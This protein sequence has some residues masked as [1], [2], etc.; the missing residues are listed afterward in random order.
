MVKSN[1]TAWHISSDKFSDKLSDIKKLQF[2]AHYAVLAPSGHNTQPWHFSHDSTELFLELNQERNLPFSGALAAEPHISLGACL[3]TLVLAA[4][5]FGYQLNITY[6]FKNK[7]IASIKLASR[8]NPDSEI[9]G[10]IVQRVSNRNNYEMN[11][12]KQGVLAQLTGEKLEFVSAQ[13]VS[14]KTEIAFLAD[15]TKQ[16][17]EH[18]MTEPK[19]R[20][21]LSKWVRNNITR[22]HDGMPGFVQGMP[23]PPSLIAKHIIRN[24]DI[25]KGQAKKDSE[26]VVNSG[27][28]VMLSI[29]QNT[30]EAFF[31]AGRMYA[32][33]CVFAQKQG[34]S[35]SGV[36]AAVID[37]LTKKDIKS[38]FGLNHQ[39]IALIRLGR[40]SKKARHSPRWP[41]SKVID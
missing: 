37:P 28:I 32:R 6:H 40:S 17:T 1:Y 30:N 27:G 34:L 33:I 38:H 3:E 13:L 16:A 15:Q 24:I 5:G 29:T 22:K 35:S 41:L 23:T 7:L 10:S 19:F 11:T 9:I 4:K 2:F 26:R 20:E 8:T 36:G 21:E 31:N 39:P 12:L 14:K 18:I 25:S